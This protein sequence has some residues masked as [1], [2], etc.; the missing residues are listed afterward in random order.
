MMEPASTL[1]VHVDAAHPDLDS[2]RQN[3]E[4]TSMD[5]FREP[6]KTRKNF[7]GC[8][9]TNTINLAGVAWKK[10]REAPPHGSHD[11]TSWQAARGSPYLASVSWA[12]EGLMAL[13]G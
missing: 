11:S 9:A 1:T 5:I 10:P 13:L 2:S 7:D 3:P 6:F 12:N 8:L 4:L